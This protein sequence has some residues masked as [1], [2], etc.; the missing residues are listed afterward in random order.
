MEI[1][2]FAPTP[3]DIA[4]IV[5]LDQRALGGLWSAQDLFARIGK[6]QQ[7]LTSFGSVL[8][9]YGGPGKKNHLRMPWQPWQTAAGRSSPHVDQETPDPIIIGVGCY[10]EIVD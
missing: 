7:L 9:Q 1:C 6:P 3:E 5:D 10:W 4:A 8:W 2:C